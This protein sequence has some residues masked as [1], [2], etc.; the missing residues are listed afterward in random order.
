VS[1]GAAE[2]SGRTCLVTGAGRG[3]G[4]AISVHLAAPGTRL[5]LHYHRSEAGARETAAAVQQRGAAAT[6]LQADLADLAARERL[7]DAVERETRTLQVLVNNVGVYPEQALLDT[8]PEDWQAVLEVTCGAVFHLTRR[9]VPLLRAGAPARVINL[10]D[11]GADRIVARPQATAYHVAKLGVH[12]LTRSFAKAL[13]ADGITVN[14]ISPGF[15]ED[16][17][18]EPGSPMPAGR[19][20]NA[21]DILGALDYL[22]SPAAAYVNGANL[23]VTGGWNA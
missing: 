16:S 9:A 7:M 18:G 10:G 3:L 11:S 5:L 19:R 17:V 2:G 1:A 15:L 6:L 13:A 12:V 8:R 14:Q 21:A 4:R 23:V 22:L 20:G